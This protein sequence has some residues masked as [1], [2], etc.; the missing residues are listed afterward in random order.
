MTTFWKA[1]P[2]HA[3]KGSRSVTDSAPRTSAIDLS[4]RRVVVVGSGIV[5]LWQAYVMAGAGADVMLIERA[6]AAFVG[7]ASRWAAAMIA[8]DCEAEGQPEALRTMGHAG[9]AAWRK[10]QLGID[11]N[12]TLVV[13]H[14]RDLGDLDRFARETRGHRLVRG[15]AL[16]AIEATLVDRFD[17]ALFFEDEAHIAAA[18][19]ADA[20]VMACRQRG[21]TFA[22]GHDWR[23]E[24]VGGATLIDCRGYDARDVC[25]GLRG[26]RGERIVVGAPDVTLQR[27][28]RLLHPRQ[29]IYVVPQGDGLFVIGA[30]V[31]ESA[32]AGA[33]TVKSALDLLNA[34]Y[35]IDSAFA[36]AEIVDIGAGTRP[37]FADNMPRIRVEDGAP[38]VIRVNGVYR[39][40][41]MLAPVL[42]EA[43]ARYMH[44]GTQSAIFS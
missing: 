8:P 7:G 35:S 40:G 24:R 27:P 11:I 21:V 29:P 3:A 30:T 28:V 10:A 25:P 2:I 22:F 32:R 44:D 39:H 17:C 33:V 43:V 19:A 13:A 31:I 23:G 38:D 18:A 6:N 16:Q 26:V 9:L 12:G 37:A 42:A 41:F 34:A 14:G 36:E 4:G 20:L 5:G 15:D 1:A